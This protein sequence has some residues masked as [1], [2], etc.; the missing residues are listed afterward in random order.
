MLTSIH[1]P[2]YPSMKLNKINNYCCHHHGSCRVTILLLNTQNVPIVIDVGYL[3]ET[4][5][6]FHL[7]E[8]ME[9][10]GYRIQNVYFPITCVTLCFHQ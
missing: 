4:I 9:T 3:A 8:V 7:H 1:R 5:G 6:S 10:V 2:E